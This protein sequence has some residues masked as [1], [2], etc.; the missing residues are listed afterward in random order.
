MPITFHKM[1]GL[2]NDFIVLD[3][4]QQELEITEQRVKQ[5]ADRHTGL[6]F[7]QLLILRKAADMRQTAAV[8][9]WNSDGSRAEQCGNGMRCLGLYLHMRSESDTDR[10]ELAGPAGVVKIE[11]L[12]DKLVRVDMGQPVF[13]THRIPVLI[14]PVNGWYPLEID[15]KTYSLGAVSMGNPHALMIVEDVDST[16]I[17][18]LGTAINL[19]SAFPRV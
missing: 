11:Y 15:R 5:L 16:D 10:F 17:A 6:G 13:D 18:A 19:H 1:H 7:D 12:Q 4:R 9:I 8:E 2:G 14:E 3:L